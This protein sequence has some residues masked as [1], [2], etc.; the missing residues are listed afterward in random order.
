MKIGFGNSKGVENDFLRKSVQTDG[1]ESNLITEMNAEK[2]K[3][4]DKEIGVLVAAINTLRKTIECI[5]NDV[6]SRVNVRIYDMWLNRVSNVAK[7]FT[8][9]YSSMNNNLYDHAVKMERMQGNMWANVLY[10]IDWLKKQVFVEL[11]SVSDLVEGFEEGDLRFLFDESTFP[12]SSE[13]K[14]KRNADDEDDVK[15]KKMKSIQEVKEVGVLGVA[16]MLDDISSEDEEDAIVSL[17]KD[18]VD[19]VGEV[20]IES[21]GELIREFVNN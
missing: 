10:D 19:E 20:D 3:E 14:L 9:F 16:G 4:M 8:S 11:D 15:S 2:L 21:F 18:D 17:Q 5:K 7:R 1:S 12:L 6:K 13:V